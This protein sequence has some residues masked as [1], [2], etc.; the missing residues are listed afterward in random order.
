MKHVCQER[1]AN[2]FFVDGETSTQVTANVWK[3][4]VDWSRVRPNRKGLQ[5]LRRNTDIS[6][7][8]L[9]DKQGCDDIKDG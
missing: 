2:S 6:T 7:R 8:A 9:R 5:L 1:D 4:E 3:Y